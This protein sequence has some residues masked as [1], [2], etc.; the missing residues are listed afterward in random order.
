MVMSPDDIKQLRKDLKAT[1]RELAA[2]LEVDQKEV[3]A[4]EAGERFPT[5]RY[6]AAMQKLGAQGPAA[7]PRAP[8]G[9]AAAKTGMQRL[10][11]AKLWEILRKLIEHPAL[12]DQVAELAAKYRDPGVEGPRGPE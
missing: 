10:A 5:K 7:I 2:A 1:A 9:K 11:D 6:V 4:W 8:K 3:V 12:F